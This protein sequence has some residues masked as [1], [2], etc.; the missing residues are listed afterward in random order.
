M[1]YYVLLAGAALIFLQGS[2]FDG[3]MKL[4]TVFSGLAFLA[5]LY[6]TAIQAFV[7]RKFC[8]WC[9]VTAAINTIVFLLILSAWF[10]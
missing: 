5:S 10:W 8:E 6:L 1:G 7:L 4:F 3:M 2:F 9:L